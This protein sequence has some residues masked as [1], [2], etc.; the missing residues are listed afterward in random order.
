MSNTFNFGV[1]GDIFSKMF[2]SDYIDIKRNVSGQ[3]KE[4]YT[5]IPCHIA[6]NSTDN[7]NP[8]S[9]DIRP[10][11]QSITVH[12]SNWVDVQNDDFIVA[13]KMNNEN[14]ILAIYNGRCGNPIVSQGRKKFVM[15]MMGTESEE[16]APIPPNLVNPS[17]IIINF[18]SDNVSVNEQMKIKIEMGDLFTFSPIQI[19]GYQVSKCYINGVEQ[20]S[21]E[22]N[23]EISQKQ[24]VIDYEYM[25]INEPTNFRYLVKGL[26]TSNDG[27][28]K[29]GYHLYKKVNIDFVSK[30]DDDYILTCKNKTL[31]HEDSGLRLSVDVGTKIVLMPQK[32]FVI[33][34]NIIDENNNSITFKTSVFNPT[35]DELN[36]YV[37]EWYDGI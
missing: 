16:S 22:I 14:K 35:D 36:A 19:D 18:N 34:D 1:I 26:Y 37:T 33:V 7:P 10:I 20:N 4:L 12:L 5:N 9:S 15:N 11:I 31:V 32:I 3:V 24:Y 6:Y 23:L 25:A 29:N 30:E 17:E 13:K 28:L 2:D 27:S 21:L 8:T